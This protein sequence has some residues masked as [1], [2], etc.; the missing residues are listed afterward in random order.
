MLTK[1]IKMAEH[2]FIGTD[3]TDVSGYNIYMHITKDNGGVETRRIFVPDYR[4]AE[5]A[6]V[7]SEGDAVIVFAKGGKVIDMLKDS[8]GK[9]GQGGA[10]PSSVDELPFD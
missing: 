5:W 10:K 4:L 1:I 7:P 6:Y 2:S 8:A 3:G 9:G